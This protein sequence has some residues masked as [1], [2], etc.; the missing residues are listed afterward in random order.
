VLGVEKVGVEDDFFMLGGHSLRAAQVLSRIS[1]TLEVELSLRVI[2][3]TP[4]VAGLAAAADAEA[5]AIADTLA[6]LDG[7][8]PEEMAALLAAIG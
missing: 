2:F 1:R 8:S 5:G 6:E 7:M 3:E 4:T